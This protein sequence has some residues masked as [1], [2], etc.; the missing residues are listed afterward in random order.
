M[1]RELKH[2]ISFRSNSFCNTES[3]GFPLVS[4][5]YATLSLRKNSKSRL[6]IMLLEKVWMLIIVGFVGKFEW[7]SNLSKSSSSLSLVSLFLSGGSFYP[8]FLRF[9]FRDLVSSEMIFPEKCLYLFGFEFEFYL[10]GR[11]MN[12]CFFYNLCF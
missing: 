7:S 8:L 9:Y 6:S 12:Q 11:T 2:G 3:N 5:K 1:V 10:V 4:T